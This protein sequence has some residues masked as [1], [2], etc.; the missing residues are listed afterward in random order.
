M[1]A[2]GRYT[3]AVTLFALAALWPVA[4]DPAPVAERPLAFALLALLVLAGEL[5]PVRIPGSV[6]FDDDLTVSAAFALAIVLL[7]G[8]AVGVA[9]Y[10]GACLIADALNRTALE[11]APTTPRSRYL[12][13][14]RPRRRSRWSRGTNASARSS[15][16]CSPCSPRRPRSRSSTTW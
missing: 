8:P 16:T 7:F 11:K 5:L 12:R 13:W 1:T 14:R 9:V 10:A 4:S 3:A 6:G 15:P 2:F